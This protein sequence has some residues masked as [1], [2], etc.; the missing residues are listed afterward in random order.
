MTWEDILWYNNMSS[1]GDQLKLEEPKE[2]RE[3]SPPNPKDSLK[4]EESEAKSEDFP[5]PQESEAK[6]QDSPKPEELEAEPKDSPRPQE[7]QVESQDSSK[8][9]EVEEAE[10]VNAKI[11]L[12]TKIVDNQEAGGNR[13]RPASVSQAFRD[14]KS[15]CPLCQDLYYYKSQKYR[16]KGKLLVSTF[17]SLCTLYVSVDINIKLSIIENNNGCTLCTDRRHT[18]SACNW[19]PLR[20]CRTPDF[21]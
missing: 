19:N 4:P 18:S 15:P 12:K 7:S 9:E 11:T 1:D 6:S 8:S 20:F 21:F 3:L 13:P 14:I 16:S 5:R 10:E 2:T 17:L